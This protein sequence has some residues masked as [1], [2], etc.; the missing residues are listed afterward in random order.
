MAINESAFPPQPLSP[1]S[2]VSDKSLKGK[3]AGNSL[4]KLTAY[5]ESD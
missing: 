5:F 1:N 3:A 2:P 4:E